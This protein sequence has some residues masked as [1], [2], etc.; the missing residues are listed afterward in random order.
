ML[1]ECDLLRIKLQTSAGKSV[2]NGSGSAIRRFWSWAQVLFGGFR[3]LVRHGV[4]ILN[5]A[6][7]WNDALYIEFS[8]FA[9]KG[10][11]KGT[12]S[13]CKE[14]NATDSKVAQSIEVFRVPQLNKGCEVIGERFSCSYY[15]LISL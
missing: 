11:P 13:Y 2:S 15:C 6:F 4:D 9:A 8:D 7:V 1:I 5:D 12:I 3:S 10:I 14:I